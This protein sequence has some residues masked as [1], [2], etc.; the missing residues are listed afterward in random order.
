MANICSNHIY[1][2]GPSDSIDEILRIIDE[3]HY[4]YVAD[5]DRTEIDGEVSINVSFDSKWRPPSAFEGANFTGVEYVLSYSESGNAICGCF[6]GSDD[7]EAWIS[8]DGTPRTEETMEVFDADPVLDEGMDR[9]H[10]IGMGTLEWIGDGSKETALKIAVV[11]GDIELIESIISDGGVDINHTDRNGVSAVSLALSSKPVKFGKIDSTRILETLL[12][13]GANLFSDSIT[14]RPPIFYGI[15]H[16]DAGFLELIAKRYA[17]IDDAIEIFDENWISPLLL[18]SECKMI[19]AARILLNNGADPNYKSLDSDSEDVAFSPAMSALKNSDE[20]MF[21]LLIEHGLDV[22][23][24]R[25]EIDAFMKN[26]P[27]NPVM[28]AHENKLLSVSLKRRDGN[29]EDA[30]SSISL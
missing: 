11:N 7:A 13:A 2:K 22:S 14:E 20:D 5:T 6:V 19:D 30:D 17:H 26:H 25:N 21:M 27:N 12:N 10:E 24:F 3:T 9:F 29:E 4:D 15:D 8:I 28:S 23:L 16:G 1:A 18:C